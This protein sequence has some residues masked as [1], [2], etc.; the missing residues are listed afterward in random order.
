MLAKLRSM[1]GE[2]TPATAPE[3]GFGPWLRAL[4]RW[5]KVA[6]GVALVVVAVAGVVSLTTTGSVTGGDGGPSGGLSGLNTNLVDRPAGSAA[7]AGSATRAEEP[8]AK[9]VFRI[10]FSFLAGFCIGAFLRAALK[11]AAIAIGFWL[12]A[13]FALQQYGLLT[14]DW[15][16]IGSVWD[17]FAAN[18]GKEW[19]SFRTFVTGS[20]PAAGLAVAGLAM[21]LKRNR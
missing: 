15:T 18:V 21:G 8:A 17:R 13:T 2:P 20:L 11:I 12:F 1:T 16:A 14:V 19:G 3:R 5:K 6:V 7:G 9:G 10:G 4:P